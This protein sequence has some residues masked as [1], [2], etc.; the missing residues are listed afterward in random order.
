MAVRATEP[1]ELNLGVPPVFWHC[2]VVRELGS[3]QAMDIFPT[4]A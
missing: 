1:E 2:A 3:L 4:V